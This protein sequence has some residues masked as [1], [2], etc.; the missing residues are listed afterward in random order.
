MFW[1]LIFLSIAIAF[2]TV[3]SIYSG[4]VELNDYIRVLNEK[5]ELPTVFFNNGYISNDSLADLSELLDSINLDNYKYFS[6]T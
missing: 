1:N 4:I 5:K 2:I 6:S 3:L